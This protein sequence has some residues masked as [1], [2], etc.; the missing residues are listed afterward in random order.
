MQ[1]KK[2]SHDLQPLIDEYRAILMPKGKQPRVALCDVASALKEEADWTMEGAQTLVM[3]AQCYGWF[4]LRN[5]TALAIVLDIE[6]GE[7]GL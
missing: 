1:K 2:P 3:L 6:D 7:C 5:A 4:V